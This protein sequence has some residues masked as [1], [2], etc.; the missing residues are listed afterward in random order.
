MAVKEF[1]QLVLDSVKLVSEGK[2]TRIKQNNLKGTYF[3]AR[4]IGDEEL[5]WSDTSY[6]LFN[7]IRGITYPGPGATTMLGSEKIIIWE[8]SYELDWPTY[9]ANSGQVVGVHPGDGAIVKTRD[10]VLLV[11]KIQTSDDRIE[12]PTW[13]I[14]TRL[15]GSY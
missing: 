3:P 13:P 9:I 11:K 6:N 10:S 7:K 8:S 12:I 15:G 1:P 5:T 2:E 4:G 14:G